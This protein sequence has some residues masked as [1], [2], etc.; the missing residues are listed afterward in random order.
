MVV[1]ERAT[2]AI[3]GWEISSPAYYNAMLR[4]PCWPGGESGLTIGIGYDL[5]QHRPE[6]V[7]ADWRD[8]LDAA[9]VGHLA[10]LAGLR[11]EKAREQLHACRVLNVPLMAA[12]EVFRG[13]TLPAYAKQTAAALPGSDQL[14]PDCF[15]ALVSLSYNRGA[16]GWTMDDDRHL[17]M[18]CIH[19]AIADGDFSS[20]ADLIRSMKR[21]WLDSDGNPLPGCA[22]LV[23]R[24]EE[25]AVMF[26]EGL[27]S[28]ASQ[29]T[30][31]AS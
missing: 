29:S 2:L 22:G 1:S 21:L 10:S 5:G 14:P 25:E 28:T 11:G 18:A 6:E 3:I 4:S 16:G 23:R 7:G 20:I 24:R 30:G 9:T 26:E 12:Q 8:H 17:E 31:V 19:D 15:G 27:A 13:V